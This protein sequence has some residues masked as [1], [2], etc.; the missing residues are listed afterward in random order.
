M[1]IVV[2]I[3]ITQFDRDFQ[4]GP[5]AKYDLQFSSDTKAY[6]LSHFFIKSGVFYSNSFKSLKFF[7]IL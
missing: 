6:R 1:W 4:N 5:F 7:I 2:N 3:T